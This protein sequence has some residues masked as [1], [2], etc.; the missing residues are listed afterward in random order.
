MAAYGSSS[1]QLF[2]KNLDDGID[3]FSTALIYLNR[4]LEAVSRP[5]LIARSVRL[6]NGESLANCLSIVPC[7][8]LPAFSLII[9]H[10]ADEMVI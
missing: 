9:G 2:D 5:V 7:Q 3:D 4:S 6:R 8:K 1:D 10:M